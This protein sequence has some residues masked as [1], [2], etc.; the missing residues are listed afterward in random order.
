[1]QASLPD[2]TIM[3]RS[4]SSTVTGLLGSMNMREPSRFARA[5]RDRHRPG[6]AGCVFCL[7]A[8]NTRYAVISLVSEAGS[9]RCCALCASERLPAVEIEQQYALAAIAG[10]VG[11]ATAAARE[12]QGEQQEE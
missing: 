8:V 4:S 11:T 7:S 2:C 6:R 9:T 10:G 12:R 5:L 3:P 1:M